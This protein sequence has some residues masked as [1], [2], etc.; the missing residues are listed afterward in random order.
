VRNNDH[1]AFGAMSAIL[2]AGLR[3][4]EDVAVVG[5][6]NL[7]LA[8]YAPVP[9]TTVEQPVDEIARLAVDLLFQRVEDT[10]TAT[11]KQTIFAKPSLV[12]RNRLSLV[13]E[14]HI[15]LN[16]RF[17]ENRDLGIGY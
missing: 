13:D 14:I 1:L 2:Y 10:E 17:N 15:W 5:F 7:S 4:P 11:P 3:I 12:V 16:G 6:D 8:A 9:L